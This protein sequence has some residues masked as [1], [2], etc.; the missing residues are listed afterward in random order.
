MQPTKTVHLHFGRTTAPPSV[1]S[2]NGVEIASSECERDL[3][4]LVDSKLQFSEHVAHIVRA[5][6]Q[7]SHLIFRCFSCR[8]LKFLVGMYKCFVRSYLEYCTQVWSPY[9]CGDIDAI[10]HVQTSF[11]AHIPCLADIPSEQRLVMCKL[12]SLELRR[13]RFDLVFLFKV[14][15][16]LTD[17][18]AFSSMF[19]FSRDITVPTILHPSTR[20][21]AAP[22][23]QY[24]LLPVFNPHPQDLRA[25]REHF[26]V[27]RVFPVWNSLPE[28]VVCSISCPQFVRRLGAVDLSAHLRRAQ[29]C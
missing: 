17:L 8:D 7:K 16:G 10:E 25:C 14:I 20:A 1:F 26:Y 3:G 19:Q 29:R 24:H 22:L 2:Y 23:H 9:K 27:N 4:I 6:A 5:A 21:A 13:L 11:L 28:R 15:H 18:L 12:D